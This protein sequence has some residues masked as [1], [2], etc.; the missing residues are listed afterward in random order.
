MCKTE[1]KHRRVPFPGLPL[2]GSIAL[3]FIFLPTGCAL[4]CAAHICYGSAFC[5]QKKKKNESQLS[6]ENTCELFINKYF[7]TTI[8]LCI[9]FVAGLTCIAI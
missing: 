6:L 2:H 8:E 9:S 4:L 5:L 1:L 3:C 7:A